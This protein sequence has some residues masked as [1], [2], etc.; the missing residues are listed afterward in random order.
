M[1]TKKR[2]EVPA[3]A[4]A[5]T[6]PALDELTGATVRLVSL[7]IEDL[8]PHPRNPRRELGDLTEL[9]DSI[10]TNGVRQPLTVVPYDAF[11]E[12]GNHSGYLVVIGHRRAA[13]AQ[14][15]GLTHVPGIVDA[16]LTP[17]Q[18]LELML[19]ENLQRADLTPVE[20]SDGYQGLLD[21]GA[22]VA[23]IASQTGRSQSTVRSRLRLRTL[24]AK[25]LKGVH[26]GKITLEDA[27]AVLTVPESERDAVLKALGTNNFATTLADARAMAERLAK[28]RPLFDILERAGAVEVPPSTS[29]TAPDGSVYYREFNGHFAPEAKALA[30]LEQQI[31]A[32]WSY[33][34]CWRTW[35][36]VY[37]PHTLDEAQQATEREERFTAARAEQEE[38]N[39]RARAMTALRAQF[40][41]VT[42]ETRREFLEHLI[43][44]R[45]SLTKDQA[46]A[47]VDYAA[48]AAADAPWAGEYIDGA[49]HQLAHGPQSPEVLATWLRLPLPEGWAKLGWSERHFGL[50]EPAREAAA[51]LAAPQRLLAALA[52]AIEPISEDVWRYGG[53]S[54]TTV[55]WYALLE[56][57]G[58]AVSDAERDALASPGP[59]DVDSDDV[60]SDD[61]EAGEE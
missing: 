16:A 2:A 48:T 47:V 32:G 58:Y 44:D 6:S 33:G 51:A 10:K 29:G 11:G 7:P 42:S 12:H 34:W 22:D 54:L 61:A 3:P 20:E 4:T 9:A 21:F 1:T 50:L 25:A 37:R 15:A 38:A 5:S 53:R 26:T 36:R 19:V 45:K 13:A 27:A 14:L 49:F 35:V 43:H 55:R 31:T 57:L 39:E 56:E 60:D 30:D 8:H 23:A 40:A 41:D 17:Q 24:P 46:S 18:Q 59:D 52:A 28:L